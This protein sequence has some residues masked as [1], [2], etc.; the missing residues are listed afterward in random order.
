MTAAVIVLLYLVLSQGKDYDSHKSENKQVVAGR[1][2][3]VKLEGNTFEKI[4]NKDSTI[5]QQDII[6]K[7]LMDEVDSYKGKLN[8]S[9]DN[10]YR[11]SKELMAYKSKDTTS[12]GLKCDSLASEVV[13]LK[14]LYDQYQQYA[15]SLTTIN[16]QQKEQYNARDVER[17]HLYAELR[18][19]YDDVFNKYTVTFSDNK[20]LRKDVKRERFKTKVAAVLALVG[21]GLFIAK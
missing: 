15:D 11:L 21:A 9:T 10:A 5:A 17:Q 4:R 13:N 7:D 18:R 16:E 2:S 20:D 12:Y 6:I 8:T 19:R 3:F 14:F 1:D